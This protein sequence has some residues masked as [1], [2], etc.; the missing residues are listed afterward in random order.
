MTDR[1]VKS[2]DRTLLI[3]EYFDQVQ[4]SVTL[5]EISEQLN[6]PKSS[7]MML[8]RSMTTLG[9]THYDLRE[10]T[11][12]PTARLSL[13]GNWV[14]EDV[15]RN[16]SLIE[17]M[18]GLNRRSNETVV[19]ASINDDSSQYIRVV[20]DAEDQRMVYRKPGTKRSLFKSSTGHALLAQLSE[21]EISGIIKRVNAYRSPEDEVI[22]IDEVEGQLNVVR[23]KGYAYSSGWITPGVS[24][25][26]MPLALRDADL[27]LAIGVARRTRKMQ[28]THEELY[29]FMRE[30]IA[31]FISDYL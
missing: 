23:S 27:P 30:S 16:G 26:A 18:H 13:L 22:R 12:R 10:R 17:L 29:E 3:L 6:L 28:Q 1:I 4:R 24:M 2:C 19:L 8:L 15:F 7:C 5:K 20:Q 14:G 21:D 11:Y 9:Y 25:I 31:S